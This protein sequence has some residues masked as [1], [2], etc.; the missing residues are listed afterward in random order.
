MFLAAGPY[1]QRRFRS[2]EWISGHFQAAELSVSTLANL[3]FVL[4]LAKLQA[5]ASYP[6]RIITAL[7][8]NFAVFSLLTLFTRILVGISARSY[9]GFLVVMVLAASFA[10]G[11]CQNAVFAYAS[12]FG[13]QEYTQAIMTGQGVAGVLPCL[14]QIVSVLSV[15]AEKT[16]DGA[17]PE[18]STSAF[19]YFLTATVISAFTLFAFVS[20]LSRYDRRRTVKHTTEDIPSEGSVQARRKTV[21]LLVLFR[22]LF[23]LAATV[24]V[25]F[26]VT[27]VFPV[28]TQQIM[29][30]RRLGTA[31]R[32]FQPASFV[33][34]AFLFWNTGDL[35]GRLMTAVPQMSLTSHLRV[36]FLLSILRIVFIPLYL[37]C[38]INNS[39]AVVESDT[40][41]LV[42][43]QFLFGVSNGFIGSSCMVGAAS[44]VGVEE[45]EAAGGFMGLMLVAGLSVGSLFSFLVA[46]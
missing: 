15:P 10:T 6:G 24:F 36:L 31:P 45:R 33:P 18:S 22:K 30:V 11:L 26:A 9:F 39:G 16:V 43:V 12:G 23:W 25:C 27:M 37:L 4:V 40:F 7:I 44:W 41:Y 32:I 19:A 42:V 29:S 38:N 5:K 3:G 14:A 21:S 28:F 20:L 34:L 35:V 46:R 2:E 1:F 8:I 17:A 13:R